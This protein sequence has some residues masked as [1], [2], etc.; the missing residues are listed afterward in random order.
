MHF[1]GC[2]SWILW[3]WGNRAFL[4]AFLRNAYLMG[5]MRHIEFFLQII[6]RVPGEHVFYLD[7]KEENLIHFHFP[8]E[9]LQ[10]TRQSVQ[11][12]KRQ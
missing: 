3:N 12:L 2:G 1:G 7:R 9:V 10:S 6:G 4:S 11:A 5:D 8:T